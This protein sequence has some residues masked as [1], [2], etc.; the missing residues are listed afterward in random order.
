M[1]AHVDSSALKR[2]RWYEYLVRFVFGA[3]ITAAA[4][5]IA[6]KYGPGL[7]GLFL[8]FPAIFPATAT[9]IEKHEN[10]KKQRAGVKGMRR[11]RAAA[12]VDAAGTAMGCVGLAAFALMM[13]TLL[14]N[15]LAWPVLGAATLLWL[16]VSVLTWLACEQMRGFRRWRAE[17]RK[18][19]VQKRAATVSRR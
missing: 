13:W 17:G 18:S 11:A 2:T 7:G 6:K 4:G 9:L 19:R 5:L 12:G 3:L 8:A 10:Q 14:P 1:K 15:H 16:G